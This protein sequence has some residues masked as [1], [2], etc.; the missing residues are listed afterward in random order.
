MTVFTFL[1]SSSVKAEA[2][3]VSLLTVSKAWV[4]I[5]FDSDKMK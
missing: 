2:V 5:F 4:V 1:I 3:M